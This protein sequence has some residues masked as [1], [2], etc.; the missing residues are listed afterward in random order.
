MKL[1]AEYWNKRYE[2]G[3]SPWD[4]GTPS[5]PLIE[6]LAGIE[7]KSIRI[8]IPG[9]GKSHDAVWAMEHGFGSV[10]VVDWAEEALDHILETYPDFPPSHLICE[11]FFDHTGHY[12]L[13]L[14]QTFFCALDPSFRKQYGQKMHDLLVP[15]GKLAG[16]WFSFP[17]EKGM[18]G[19]TDGL[20]GPP[21]GGS[22]EEYK[23]YF[24]EGWKIRTLEP[25][26]N[27]IPPRMGNELFGIFERV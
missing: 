25:C 27:S 17:L 20:L 1:N 22:V 13:V 4:L 23:G 3:N 8:L 26:R 11:D 12:D 21:F 5:P 15:G 14:E 19:R 6:Y 2:E 18:P 24:T 7:D 16:V 10:Y 9:A